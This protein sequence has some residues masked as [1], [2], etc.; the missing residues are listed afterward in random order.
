MD[1]LR[2]CGLALLLAFAPGACAQAI[3]HAG[4]EDSDD[5]SLE[6]APVV[7]VLRDDRVVTLEMDYDGEHAWGQWWTMSGTGL[8]DAGFLVTWWPQDAA[9]AAL[10]RLSTKHDDGMTG[11]LPSDAAT[12]KG[13][14]VGAKWMVT[15]NRRVQL[16][17][18]DNNRRYYVR[19]ERLDA[20]GRISSLP[21]VIAFDGGDGARVAALR[22]Q[23]TWFD[24]FNLPMG[25]ADETLWNNATA[26]STDRRFNLF[27][28]N[29]QYHAHT[30][31][32]TRV[33]NTGDK[34]QT[35]Q[36][37]RK[38][39]RIEAGTRRR[40][41]FDMD[42]PLAPRAVWYLDLN[43]VGTDATGHAD[44]FDEEGALGLPAGILRL[45]SQFQTFSVSLIGMD[46][47][48]H[49][50][51]SV[52]MEAAGRQ[53]VSNVRRHFE[54]FVGTGDIEVKIDGRTVIDDTF[55]PYALAPGDYEPLW[56]G[57]GYN[58][59][60]DANPYYLVHWDNFGFD[61][62]SVEPRRVHNYVTRIEGTDYAKAN[63]NN[64]QAPTFTVN[65][66]D[67][68][69]PVT[70][71]ATAEAWLVFTYQMGD[72]SYVTLEPGDHVRVN[73]ATDYA[74]P[75][76]INNSVP[77]RP[78]LLQ[79]GMP[80]TVRIKLGELVQ[81]GLSPLK[82]GGNTFQF[83]AANTGLI[84]L[85]VEVFYPP[86]SAP[87]YTPPSAIH[88]F[89]MHAELPRLGTPARLA[90]IGDT[91][92]GG[93]HHLTNPGRETIPV[94]GTVP[95][96][97]TVGNRTWADWAPDLMVFPIASTEVWSSGGTAGIEKVEVFL[98]PAGGA[99]PGQRI[100][101]IETARDAPAPQGR[102]TIAFDTR[103]FAD[104]DYDL[105]VRATAPSG[106]QSHPSY[107]DETYEWDAAQL[108]G[109]YYPI[110]I[111]IEN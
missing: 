9:S 58:T 24:D 73:D 46:G 105:F 12:P 89:P 21:T 25:A 20:F 77:V 35:A 47:A 1:V 76:R 96:D 43:P 80:H 92:V 67:D 106:L 91:N 60:K 57:F 81:G 97:I 103:A 110:S 13:T 61:G 83:F 37:F 51:A 52:D 22:S 27:F 34:S 29:D 64:G 32:G 8:D 30:L 68:L 50:I 42:S 53:A 63:R 87:A 85:H 90:K 66:P 28:I 88:H 93:A 31:N 74:L 15:G 79:W 18:L 108:S 109:A 19:V 62:P 49:Q 39:L 59:S 5:P 98:R 104:G 2:S 10:D 101:L 11:C 100:R 78:E 107:G 75:P 36:R 26:T 16:Q 17:P 44:F 95:L 45:R 86:G 70:A 111:R 3:F 82:I 40:I 84:N 41:V 54:V 71:G 65:I 99:A 55:A 72:Y 56:V 6:A 48:S 33:D 14:P 7:T 4:F 23:L 102:Y 69:R 38:P 94:S